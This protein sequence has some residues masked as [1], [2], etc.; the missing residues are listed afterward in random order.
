MTRQISASCG[1]YRLVEPLGHGAMAQVYRGVAPDGRE[2][3][4][5][6]LHPSLTGDEG[7]VARFSREAEA[8]ASLDHPHIVHV[9][10][11]GVE[12]EQHYLVMD[13]VNG[14]SLQAVL[15]ARAQPLTPAEAIALI[16]P[17]AEA[18]D[19]AH[20]RG[21]IHRDVKPSNILLREGRL[22][23]PVLTDFGVARM[24]EATVATQAGALLGTPAYMAP[25]QGEG[26]PGD[27]RSDVY[28][29]GVILYELLTGQPPFQA[30]SPY[31]VILRHIHT[32][33]PPLRSLRPDLPPALEAVVLRALEKDPAARYPSAAAF[34]AAL[35]ASLIPARRFRHPALIAAATVV[36]LLVLALAMGWRL[37]WLP[38]GP[39]L[40]GA[41]AARSTPAVLALQ[42]GPTILDTW[43][44]PDVPDRPAF[45][46]GKIHLQGPSTPD[47]VLVKLALP[48][49]SA[50]TKLLTATLSLYTVPWKA[51]EN[52]F[53]TVAAHR[54]LTDWDVTTATYETPW[55][56]AGMEPDVDY[57]ATP[58]ITVTLT[59]LLT[60]K[61]WLDLDI[62][63]LV[64]DWLEGQPNH[65]LAV[66]MT[67]DS[68]GMAHL[69]VY[70]G[71]YEDP[72][73]WPKLT[74]VYRQE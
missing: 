34:A 22:D 40:G 9:L 19:Y 28:A 50:D 4:V 58:F 14:P 12:G 60:E 7:F 41:Q 16:A 72:N 69:W 62:T 65:G 23:D 37:G 6:L 31:A 2:V 33:P 36:M 11:H 27:E 53:A 43:L 45:D 17:L 68:F 26:K 54:I 66:R 47:R 39:T 8:A 38:R 29:L 48:T 71:E 18:L 32:P 25:E 67:D 55:H 70:T 56:T 46:D 52:R 73:L 15:R 10:D 24:V 5:K 51:E 3:A 30:D 61:G 1:P 13:L 49:W 35:T 63:P 59:T 42:G 64:R 57:E 44:D 20:R 74:L 21:V